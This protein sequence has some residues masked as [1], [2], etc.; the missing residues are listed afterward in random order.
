M[1]DTTRD[2][3]RQPPF[4]TGT[5]FGD[6]YSVCPADHRTSPLCGYYPKLRNASACRY[7]FCSSSVESFWN[8][9]PSRKTLHC[10][11]FAI[12]AARRLAQ[13]NQRDRV[14]SSLCSP[15]L[16]QESPSELMSSTGQVT[17][18]PHPQTSA[19]ANRTIAS[20]QSGI[21]ASLKSNREVCK[22]GG[23]TSPS[24]CKPT[25]KKLAGTTGP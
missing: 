14:D 11:N 21:T 22:S 7:R 12:G 13:C 25:K 5:F 3:H 2:S 1:P 15:G 17:S 16:C 4:R 23:S 19:K 10:G 18:P 8:P 9:V 6:S 20:T 24:R